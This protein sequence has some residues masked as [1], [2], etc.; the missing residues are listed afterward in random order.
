M[1]ER[2]DQNEPNDKKGS[3]KKNEF[4]FNFYWIYAIIIVILLGVSLIDWQGGGTSITPSEFE[5]WARRGDVEK[6]IIQ[7]EQ[8]ALVTL[9]KEALQEEPHVSKVDEPLFGSRVGSAPHYRF[10]IGPSEAFQKRLDKIREESDFQVEW[11]Q[12]SNWGGRLLQWL[13]PIGLMVALWIFLMRRLSSQSGG[14]G[15]LFNIGKSK[16]KVFEKDESPQVNFKDVAGSAEAKEEIQEIVDFLKHPQ[17]YTEL[18]AEIPKGALLIGQPGTGKTLL[19]KAVAGEANV[20]FFSISGSDFVEMFVG[21]GASRVRDLFRQAKEKAPAIIFIDEIDAIGRARNRAPQMGGNDERENT[22][23]QL[24]SEMDGFDTNSGII[25]MGA[26][27]RPEVLDH[28]LLRPGRFDRRISVDMPD[29]NERKEILQVHLAKLQIDESID[30]EH[31]A[32]QTPGFSGADL[33]NICNEAALTAARNKKQRIDENDFSNAVDRVIAG[34]E[35]KNKIISPS[36]KKVIAYHEAGHAVVSWL[37]EH[38][39]PLVKVSVV[40]RGETLGAAWYLPEERQINTTPQILDELCAALGGRAAEEIIFDQISTGALNDLE[41][42]TKQAYAMVSVYGLSDKLGNRSYYDPNGQG[43][44]FTKP[45]SDQTAREIDEEAGRII[46]E[47]YER[48]KQ[49]ISD[50]KERLTQLAEQLLEE[51]VIFK[52]DLERIFGKKN[53]S[54]G[55]EGKAEEQEGK[56]ENPEEGAAYDPSYSQESSSSSQE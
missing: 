12:A 34:L 53:G 33:A 20:P 27:N 7:N 23:N 35:K 37:V 56:V 47:T 36:E 41:K 49:I 39:S 30:V 11:K 8:N 5:K 16:A 46:E 25:L 22:L 3:E 10:N 6:V 31:L 9:K 48:A 43:S 24:L 38:A 26:T 42:V 1:S 55:V 32:R 17:K 45:Y 28:A 19:A 52:E 21:V 50:N 29:L 14:G 18:G 15:Q 40:P 44:Q 4:P 51:E 13:I 2:S 54:N